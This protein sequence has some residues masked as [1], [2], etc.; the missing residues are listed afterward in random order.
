MSDSPLS[1]IDSLNKMASV[2]ATLNQSKIEN[3][4]Q[5]FTNLMSV[6]R[7]LSLRQFCI[8]WVVMLM[9]LGLLFDVFSSRVFLLL[10]FLS[11]EWFSMTFDVVSQVLKHYSCQSQYFEAVGMILLNWN[12]SE[13]QHQGGSRFRK[14]KKFHGHFVKRQK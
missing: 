12:G 6:A 8:F 13:C 9:I 7:K 2:W 1:G 4:Q 10:S 3:L 14:L 11:F 5:M